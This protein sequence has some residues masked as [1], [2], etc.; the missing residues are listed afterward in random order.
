MIEAYQRHELLAFP[1]LYEGFGLVFLEGMACG[2]TVIATS[3]G[4]VVDVIRHDENGYVVRPGDPGALATA[5]QEL[6]MAPERRQR[7]GEAARQTA[8]DYTWGQIAARTLECY[9]V[10]AKMILERGLT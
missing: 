5:I 8:R 1:S 6:W 4:G 7:L 2:M 10:A 3:T 9:R